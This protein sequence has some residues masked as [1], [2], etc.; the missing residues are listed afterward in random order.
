LD[1]GERYVPFFMFGHGVERG[2]LVGDKQSLISVAP[3]IAYLL[4]APFPDHSRGRV[5]SEAIIANQKGKE[6]AS[7]DEAASGR[8]FAG[9]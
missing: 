7:D 3:T 9:A 5:L 4:G 2:K 6:R 1:E 8:V